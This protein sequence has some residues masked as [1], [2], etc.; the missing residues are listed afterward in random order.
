MAGTRPERSPR[1][2]RAATD[3]RRV[4]SPRCTLPFEPMS[5]QKHAYGP[6]PPPTFSAAVRA[7][8]CS[9]LGGE[10]SH[11]DASRCDAHA[12]D[13][14]FDQGKKTCPGAALTR[15][16]AVRHDHCI[17]VERRAAGTGLLKD[18]PADTLSESKIRPGHVNDVIHRD[19][20]QYGCVGRCRDCGDDLRG[21]GS[22]EG[23]RK[24]GA[25]N[26]SLSIRQICQI[27]LETSIPGPGV[28]PIQ[29][30]EPRRVLAVTTSIPQ[31]AQSSDSR[32]ACSKTVCV[33]FSCLSGG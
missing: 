11:R 25:P 4:K 5:T 19:L 22:E 28:E 20:A 18:I 13:G 27:G 7:I 12:A 15:S 31:A 24:Q 16:F 21:T 1:P 23:A 9:P 26:G 30:W 3:P 8:T 32:S 6:P 33:A 29:A 10:V 2:A 14:R 17:F